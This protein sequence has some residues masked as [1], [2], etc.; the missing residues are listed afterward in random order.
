MNEDDKINKLNELLPRLSQH[1]RLCILSEIATLQQNVD[2]EPTEEVQ[3]DF[4]ETWIEL[5][6]DKTAISAIQSLANSLSE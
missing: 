4:I 5:E 3:E 6:D 2:G 1:D